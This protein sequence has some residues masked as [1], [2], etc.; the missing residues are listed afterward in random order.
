MPRSRSRSKNS[1]N[2]LSR[3]RIG[4]ALLLTLAATPLGGCLSN[5]AFE[6][7]AQDLLSTPATGQRLE[8]RNSVGDVTLIADPAATEIRA[9][10]K[11]TGKG[12]S[13]ARAEDALDD[14]QV[15]LAPNDQGVIVARADHSAAGRNAQYE[16]AWKIT[17]PPSLVVSIIN[18]VGD[19]NV[20]GFTSGLVVAND[21]GDVT[22][23]DVTGG[24]KVQT[25]VGDLGIGAAAPVDARSNVGDIKVTVIPGA[26]APITLGADVGTI[27]LTMPALGWG[28]IDAS[29]GTGDA[30][31]RLEGVAVDQVRSEDDLFRA[32]INGGVGPMVQARSGVGDVTVRLS[33]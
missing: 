18:D 28:E 20:Q 26:V 22:V 7:S 23:R 15:S 25:D 17:A 6:R 33:K 13:P 10:V 30:N 2:D 14:I 4:R 31:V 27:T 29:C 9:E 16:V 21:V 11:L 24:A 3:T 8:V 5:N 12:S 1:K 19:I 32:K